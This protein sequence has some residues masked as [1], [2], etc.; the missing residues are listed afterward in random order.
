M[1]TSI[2]LA[3]GKYTVVHENGMNLRVLRYGEPWRDCG[4]DALILTLAQEVVTLRDKVRQLDPPLVP[5]PQC[6]VCGTTFDLHRDGWYGYRCNSS[7][8]VCY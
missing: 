7:D 1:S 8:C 3:G 4:G 5:A 6:C 2:E